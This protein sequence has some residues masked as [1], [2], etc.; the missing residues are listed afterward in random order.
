MIPL[1]DET[2]LETFESNLSAIGAR[3]ISK[4]AALVSNIHPNTSASFRPSVKC[5]SEW[6]RHSTKCQCGAS[7]DFDNPQGDLQT[8]TERKFQG[9]QYYHLTDCDSTGSLWR[10]SKEICLPTV[11]VP[12]QHMAFFN[13]SAAHPNREFLKLQ[14]Q[15]QVQAWSASWRH[16]RTRISAAALEWEK[17]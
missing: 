17:I 1:R 15:G 8:S 13:N 5:R 14:I 3:E 10:H 9:Y 11:P 6:R 7:S 16:Q 4:N 2:D 12:V